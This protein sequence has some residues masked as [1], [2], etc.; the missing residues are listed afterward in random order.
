MD[1]NQC[2]KAAMDYFTSSCEVVNG[3]VD[4]RKVLYPAYHYSHIAL[5]YI[6]CRDELDWR[7]V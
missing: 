7:E 1:Y 6:K 3:D 2:Q 5:Y 4:I